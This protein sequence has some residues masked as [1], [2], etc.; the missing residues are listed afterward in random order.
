M[1][2]SI[3]GGETLGLVGESGCG[4][5]TLGRCIVRGIEATSG[6]VL[7]RKENGE[8]VDFL[9]LNR[10]DLSALATN[11]KLIVA[12]EAVSA[13]DVSIQ[14]QVLNL[15]EELQEEFGLTYI[16]VAHDLSVVEHISDRV[17]VMYVGRVVE[18]AD[19]ESIFG[20]PMH[21][22]TEALMSA[23]PKPDPLNRMKRIVLEG[24]VPSPARPPSGCHF[25]PRCVYAKDICSSQVPVLR[26]V[27]REHFAACHFA[28]S[29]KLRG[30]SEGANCRL[31]RYGFAACSLV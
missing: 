4:K 11:P 9:K 8:R 26:E 24:E 25:H 29:L 17:S 23:V 12:D 15:L 19:T 6:E 13:L 7:Y 10:K 16:F 27:E 3:S 14:A 31:W 1:S 28:E 22:Y 30:V 21:P 5:T 18:T 20:S 2:L